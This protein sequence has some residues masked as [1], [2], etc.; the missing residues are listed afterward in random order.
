[1]CDNCDFKI[2]MLVL[3]IIEGT[4]DADGKKYCFQFDL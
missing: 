3:E 1:M 2:L 4:T